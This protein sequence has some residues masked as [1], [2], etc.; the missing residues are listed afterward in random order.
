VF[1]SVCPEFQPHEA[2][3]GGHRRNISAAEIQPR[4]RLDRTG[5][6]SN[7]TSTSRATPR[8]S[9]ST[10][11]SSASKGSSRNTEITRIA[12][13]GPRPGSRS[14]THRRR[15]CC[16]S[17]IGRKTVSA[18][19]C[20]GPRH[21]EAGPPEVGMASTNQGAPARAAS[22]FGP[23][24]CDVSDCAGVACAA[25]CARCGAGMLS[26]PPR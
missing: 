8:S 1:K 18:P 22:A 15:Q 14:R 13:G 26:T 10:P 21:S 6:A 11:A 4:R 23:T 25:R 17:R 9:L 2:N 12:R 24:S 19:L 3:S 20:A 16:D 7:T 5:L